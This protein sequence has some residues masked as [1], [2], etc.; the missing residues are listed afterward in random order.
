M[1]MAL[2][3]TEIVPAMAGK[4]AVVAPAATITEPCTGSA[5]LLLVSVTVAPPTGAGPDR[6]AVQVVVWFEFRLAGA[7]PKL[8]KVGS[9]GG[10]N[11]MVADWVV[12][13]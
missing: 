4:V 2:S 11:A 13:V 3:V 9:A 7:H 12:L 8:V 1:I 5:G 6:V 10:T